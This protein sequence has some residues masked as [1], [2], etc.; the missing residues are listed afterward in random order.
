M[1]LPGAE[2]TSFFLVWLYTAHQICWHHRFKRTCHPW[3]CLGISMNPCSSCWK[4]HYSWE[5]FMV[6]TRTWSDKHSWHQFCRNVSLQQVGCSTEAAGEEQMSKLPPIPSVGRG[7]D[8]EGTAGIAAKSSRECGIN[9]H[10]RFQWK[11][12]FCFSEDTCFPVQ[13]T[14]VFW[15]DALLPIAFISYPLPQPIFPVF[16]ENSGSSRNWCLGACSSS[17]LSSKP[18]IK[19]TTTTW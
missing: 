10:H 6:R 17:P 19:T 4:L 14:T 2:L 1:Y 5:K 8:E 15:S 9:T 7:Q 11:L 13:I 3:T 18:W 16:R 12:G